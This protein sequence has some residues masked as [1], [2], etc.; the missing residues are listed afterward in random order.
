[1]RGSGQQ[2]EAPKGLSIEMRQ[3]DL[4]LGIELLSQEPEGMRFFQAPALALLRD[5]AQMLWRL[6]GELDTGSEREQV[7]QQ[8]VEEQVAGAIGE[9]VDPFA[10]G[11]VSGAVL[12]QL[13]HQ[14]PPA[15]ADEQVEGDHLL[16]ESDDKAA[17]GMKKVRQ[18]GVGATAH[19][20]ADALDNQPVVDFGDR[21]ACV[22]APTNQGAGG[23]AVGM[24]ALLGER[25]YGLC[26]LTCSN[27]FFDGAGKTLYNDHGLGT[28]PSRGPAAKHRQHDGGC[29]PFWLVCRHYPHGHQFRQA[30]APAGPPARPA[31]V[32]ALLLNQCGRLCS[33]ARGWLWRDH[34]IWPGLALF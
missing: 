25:E 22:G 9:R 14:A 26:A 19:L 23:L 6:A 24:R 8:V 12:G 3:A 27:V 32:P 7:A 15:E 17:M 5:A 33:K 18:Q 29:R 28:P 13:A 4:D 1:M 20:A 11:G 34:P 16:Q 21:H 31:C 2:K 10:H 30:P